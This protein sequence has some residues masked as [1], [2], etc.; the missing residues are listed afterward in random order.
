MQESGQN[1]VEIVGHDIL[2]LTNGLRAEGVD[3]DFSQACRYLSRELLG[4]K[5]PHLV[6]RDIVPI[7][8]AESDEV[9]LLFSGG[10]VSTATALKLKSMGKKVTLFHLEVDKET[11]DRSSEISKMLGLPLVTLD[12]ALTGKFSHY[13]YGMYL[14]HQAIEYAVENGYSPKIYMGCFHMA[15]VLNN[16]R[17]DWRYCLEFINAY[18][19]VIRKYVYGAEIVRIIPSYSVAD[20]EFIRHKEYSKFFA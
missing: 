15:S 5:M 7:R 2:N 11:S 3:Y 18:E 13:F 10:R 12:C 17:E 20:D 16:D 9:L 6:V 19:S 8:C 4:Y 1:N 14:A